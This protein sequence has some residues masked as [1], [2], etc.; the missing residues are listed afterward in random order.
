MAQSEDTI[1]FARKVKETTKKKGQD[2]VLSFRELKSHFD[3]RFEAINK[4][5]SVE[6]KHLPER[7]KKP[8]VPPF[9]YKGNIIQHV[10]NMNLIEYMEVLTHFIQKGSISRATKA[11]KNMIEDL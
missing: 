4:K 2:Q 3:K 11:V 9:N 10:L 8:A 5:F 1:E 6:T 7:L